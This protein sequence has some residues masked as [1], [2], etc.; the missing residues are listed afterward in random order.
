VFGDSGDGG[1]NCV[2]ADGDFH[3]GSASVSAMSP[4]QS[5]SHML[6]FIGFAA[7]HAN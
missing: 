6:N 4:H 5:E 7:K 3:V 2:N 1:D